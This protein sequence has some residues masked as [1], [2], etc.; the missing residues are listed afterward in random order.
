MRIPAV[1][2]SYFAS[3]IRIYNM[4][5]ITILLFSLLLIVPGL[6]PSQEEI[7]TKENV[8]VQWWVVPFFAVD[9]QGNSVL[10]L[11]RGDIDI[12][13]D[14]QKLDSFDI[15][16]RDFYTIN[17][18][19]KKELQKVSKRY[20]FLVF[21]TTLSDVNT[22]R[23]ARKIAGQIVKE[24]TA[25]N[26][27]VVMS[28]EPNRGL[29]Y[30]AGPI[31][32]K[33]KILSVLEKKIKSKYK[34]V[35]RN[36]INSLT[37]KLERM[38]Q[39]QQAQQQQ[40]RQGAGGGQRV[41]A[42]NTDRIMLSVYQYF[43]GIQTM[44]FLHSL[45]TLGYSLRTLSENKFVYFFSEGIKNRAFTDSQK[46]AHFESLCK[47]VSE[48]INRNGAVLININ[49]SGNYEKNIKPGDISLR[50]LA[51]LSGGKYIE[52]DLKDI[53]KEIS[54]INRAY[55]EIAFPD[56]P[57]FTG[58]SHLISIKSLREGVATYSLRSLSRGKDY[59]KMEQIEKEILVLSVL[60]GGYLAKEKLKLI[61]AKI[62][63][64]ETPQNH[65]RFRVLLP[66]SF[67][68][69]EIDIF[70]VWQNSDV[71]DIKIKKESHIF[72][73]REIILDAKNKKGYSC[74]LVL[75]HGGDNSAVVCR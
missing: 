4:K 65:H 54:N 51:K 11:K 49:P 73:E 41:P 28:I 25:D 53:T 18:K 26:Y 50:Y 64:E 32:N 15:Y 55:Y 24:S 45:R 40:P 67:V 5:K 61:K 3:P 1:S 8:S 27:F 30:L 74:A 17:E 46:L 71:K 33:D 63:K 66:D 44:V 9:G 56:S 35:V 58:D 7:K 69:K 31:N 16:K 39:M 6:F 60:E 38:R 23:R 34:Q 2:E 20:V 70:K 14:K 43:S 48:L 10:D 21:D 62:V 52:G 72:R 42:E 13:V 22:V 47:S 12:F 19:Q 59:R 75:I 29:T 36:L 37:G 57:E 68:G